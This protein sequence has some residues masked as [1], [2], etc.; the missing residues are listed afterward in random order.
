MMNSMLEISLALLSLA[1]AGCMYRLLKGP[2][3]SDRIAALDTIGILLL[4]M[5]AV[6][7]MLEGTSAYFDI[8]LVIGIVTFI[9]T[10]AFAR[11]I[12]RGAVMEDE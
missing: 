8:I 12:E 2:S 5:I 9:G 3:I 1:A 10:T 6:L 7:G 11:Y 4:S